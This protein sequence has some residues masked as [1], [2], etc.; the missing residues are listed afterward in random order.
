M[1]RRARRRWLSIAAIVLCLP[2]AAHAETPDVAAWPVGVAVSENGRWLA[3]GLVSARPRVAVWQ[4]GALHGEIPLSGPVRAEALDID[5]AGVLSVGV[6]RLAAR[7]P[8]IMLLQIAPE[9]T[10]LHNCRS[11]LADPGQMRPTQRRG[12]SRLAARGAQAIAVSVE[13]GV[14]QVD[15]ATC[16]ITTLAP[17]PV[18]DSEREAEIWATDNAVTVQTGQD[19]P[20]TWDWSGAPTSTQTSPCAVPPHL[21]ALLGDDATYR[22]SADCTVWAVMTRAALHLCNATSCSLLWRQEG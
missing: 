14:H 8:Q 22:A 2:F 19:A 10:L 16:R 18:G 12:I 1:T 11:D 4:D 9:G 15:L 20:R 3:L 21:R 5:D 17:I 7:N 13:G 6:T